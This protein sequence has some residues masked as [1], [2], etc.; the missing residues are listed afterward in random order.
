MKKTKD[1]RDGVER[2]RRIKAI[3][4]SPTRILMIKALPE[5]MRMRRL[6]TMSLCS[7]MLMEMNFW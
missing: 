5:E 1:V 3:K 2:R 4:R 7:N 6:I